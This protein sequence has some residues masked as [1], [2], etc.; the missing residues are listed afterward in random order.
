MKRI[1]WSFA[2]PR[3]RSTMY[4]ARGEFGMQDWHRAGNRNGRK[5]LQGVVVSA[6]SREMAWLFLPF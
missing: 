3:K 1:F 2:P 5:S 6:I 4:V